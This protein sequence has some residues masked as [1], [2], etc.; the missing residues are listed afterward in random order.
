M[1]NGV[2]LIKFGL[3]V[4]V[5]A[6]FGCGESNSGET[7]KTVK[8]VGSTQEEDSTTQN[9]PDSND[10]AIRLSPMETVDAS[11]F[12]AKYS[13]AG[14][15]KSIIGSIHQDII[16]AS[17]ANMQSLLN[18]ATSSGRTHVVMSLVKMTA[19][20][21]A[22]IANGNTYQR[23]QLYFVF[24]FCS[25][26]AGNTL[27]FESNKSYLACGTTTL[28]TCTAGAPGNPHAT[29]MAALNNYLAPNSQPKAALDT[30]CMA[31]A[32]QKQEVTDIYY[33]IAELEVFL[34]AMATIGATFNNVGISFAE[35]STTGTNARR[36]EFLYSGY[37]GSTLIPGAKYYNY[38][39]G[40]P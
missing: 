11:A 26:G 7:S 30:Y 1:K 9:A 38:S 34:T 12:L 4:L 36:F 28:L 23:N 35:N 21:K 31:G 37:N 14:A 25:L 5:A 24:R 20:L 16:Y 22:L 6:L 19:G 33:P 27:I 13:S 40:K 17:K 3:T 8:D 2:L 15:T 10:T 18:A 29:V 39:N 32:A